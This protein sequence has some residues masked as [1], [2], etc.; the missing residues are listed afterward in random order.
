M[1]RKVGLIMSI[2]TRKYWQVSWQ[3]LDGMI[4]PRDIVCREEEAIVI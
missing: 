1:P 3:Q 4:A 2:G